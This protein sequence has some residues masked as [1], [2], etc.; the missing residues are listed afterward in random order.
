MAEPTSTSTTSTTSST[1][2]SSS[3]TTC[4]TSTTS[5]STSKSTTQSVQVTSQTITVIPTGGSATVNL[6]RLQNISQ[7]LASANLPNGSMIYS[8][9]FVVSSINIEINGVSSPV[10]LATGGTTLLV[11]LTTPAVV[12]GTVAILLDL[13]PTIINTPTGYQMIPSSIGVIKQSSEI[14][15]QDQQ[16]GYTHQLTDQD[17]NQIKQIKGQATAKLVSLSVSGNKST[18]IV[19]VS[20]TGCS[21]VSVET[22][23]LTGNF[24]ALNCVTTTTTTTAKD[25]HSNPDQRNCEN[26]NQIVFVPSLPTT[27]TSTTTT[28]K[29]TSTTTSGGCTTGQMALGS[30]GFALGDLGFGG[31]GN[32]QLVLAPGQCVGLTFSGTISLGPFSN[33]LVPSTLPGQTYT[34]QLITSNSAY[35]N[36]FCMIPFMQ[37]SCTS[38][39]QGGQNGQGGQGSQGGQ[40]GQGYQ[41]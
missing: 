34:V 23:G 26:T 1:T 33:V 2:T 21:S 10:I 17:Q 37:Q 20:N 5:T 18:I 28:A 38:S 27:L 15:D 3:T 30:L 13:N 31:N 35:A 36:P 32:N 8:V 16:V 4:T 24:T 12:R 11:A 9:T 7:T 19:E 6:L 39:N 22:I 41:G 29:T 14:T 40:G 25:G